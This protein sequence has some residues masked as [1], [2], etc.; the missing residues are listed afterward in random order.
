MQN[1]YLDKQS[2]LEASIGLS[3][4]W[5]AR[6][7]GREVANSVLKKL[8]NPPSFFLLFSTIHYKDHGGFEEFLD[9]VWD[10]LPKGTPLIGGTV[11]GFINNYGCYT[12]GATALAVSYP[13]MD[14]AVG[15]GKHTRRNPKRAARNCANTMK[16]KL[17][18]SNYK[19]KF[20][21]DVIS[22]PTIPFGKINV[23]KS[24]FSGWFISYV[25]Y[26]IFPFLGSGVGRESEVILQLSSYMPEYQ[27]IGGSAVDQ[28]KMLTNFQFIDN[29]IHTD[30]IV[31]LGCSADLP[32]SLRGII[33]LHETDKTFEIT[34]TTYHGMIIK[35]I[36]NKP[37]KKQFFDLLELPEEQ[38][39]ELEYFYYKTSDYYP[40]TF[41]ENKEC[42][43]GVC[44]ILGNNLPVS[45]TIGG[46][47]AR[48]LSITG[49]EITE[50]VRQLL[51]EY[52]KDTYPFILS[53]S[54][55]AYPF[56]LGN[57]TFEIKTLLD[58]KLRETPYLM[59][60]PMVENIR[61]IG[62]EPSIRVYSTNIFSLGK[63]SRVG[64]ADNHK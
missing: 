57:K 9:G 45:H 1:K 56:M 35:T 8:E 21:I 16:N 60:Y 55:A 52:D 64:G 48:L 27:I 37:A 49:K 42:V 20:L 18:K 14:V 29:Q 26:R 43:I 36:N 41:E 6:D 40:I 10:V 39:K 59:V 12:R 24:K 7:A 13:N 50:N 34:G 3:R 11:A 19:N 47:H 44:G 46:K 38:F 32:I 33:G 15:I 22:A 28:G 63:F 53:F 30:S 61:I 23:I 4:K 2:E 25:V 58:Q 5:D 51:Q 31:A 62:K 17:T 54:S